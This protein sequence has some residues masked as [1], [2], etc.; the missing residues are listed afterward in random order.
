MKLD[1]DIKVNIINVCK[2]LFNSN[3][4]DMARALGIRRSQFQ[5]YVSTCNPSAFILKKIYDYGISVDYILSG[6]GSMFADNKN[7]Q[8]LKIRYD[9]G[10]EK[11]TYKIV[12]S[13]NA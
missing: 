9:L 10:Y 8:E 7:G 6:N 12:T 5:T 3:M 4:S 2:V 11:G 13:K 1:E